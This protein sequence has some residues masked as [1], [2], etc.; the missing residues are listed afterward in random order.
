MKTSDFDVNAKDITLS[1]YAEQYLKEI[2]REIADTTYST[3]YYR[4]QRIKEGFGDAKLAELTDQDIK[5]FLDKD[6]E[7]TMKIYAKVK[8]NEAKGEIAEHLDDII[9]TKNYDE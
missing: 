1:E 6:I 2:Q 7:T 8:E 3:Y 9:P 4:V 5:D